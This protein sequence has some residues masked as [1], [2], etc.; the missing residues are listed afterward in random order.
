LRRPSSRL[1]QEGLIP[2]PPF[3]K[4]LINGVDFLFGLAKNARLSAEIET[5]LAAAQAQSQHTRRR[6]TARPDGS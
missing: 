5:E 1:A 2:H 3:R 6:E 4:P